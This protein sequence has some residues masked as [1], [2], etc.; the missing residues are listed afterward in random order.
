VTHVGK[1]ADS[2]MIAAEKELSGIARMAKEE[3]DHV[4]GPN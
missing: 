4:V 1:N 2:P 3:P